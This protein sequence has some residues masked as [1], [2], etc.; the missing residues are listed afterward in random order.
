MVNPIPSRAIHA[1]FDAE[2]NYMKELIRRMGRR[3]WFC[4]ASRMEQY[5]VLSS[6]ALPKLAAWFERMQQRPAVQT[7]M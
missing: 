1:P 6:P 2:T 3:I 7:A 5:G 4:R